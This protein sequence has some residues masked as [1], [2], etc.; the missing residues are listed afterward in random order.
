[1]PSATALPPLVTKFT[2][3]RIPR[4]NELVHE[5]LWVDSVSGKILQSQHAFYEQRICPDNVVD[6]GGRI[7]APGFL[8]VQLNGAQGFDFSVPH[9]TKESYDEGLAE[10]NRGLARMG[11][12]SYLPT[13]VSQKKE[14]YPQV[15]SPHPNTS[16]SR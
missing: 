9:D 12:T 14:V 4:G 1:M 2:N 10:V 11:I 16:L 3:C 7:L 5:D 13:I 15:S 8:E 6:L